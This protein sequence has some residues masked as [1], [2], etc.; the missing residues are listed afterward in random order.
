MNSNGSTKLKRPIVP[1]YKQLSRY[2]EDYQ[3][4][5]EQIAEK[6]GYNVKYIKNVLGGND[7]LTD[8][9]KFRFLSHYRETMYI[10]LPEEE[11][12]D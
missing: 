9:A 8:G 1:V 11:T 12:T 2:F 3:I 7:P 4:P 5:V 6:T 10:H